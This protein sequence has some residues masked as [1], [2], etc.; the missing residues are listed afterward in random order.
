MVRISLVAFTFAASLPISA[1]VSDEAVESEIEDVAPEDVVSVTAKQLIAAYRVNEIR[2]N[3]LFQGKVISVSGIV[4]NVGEDIM[5][6]AYV[7][8]TDGSEFSFTRVQCFFGDSH[9]NEL[10][11]LSR[12][13]R[14]TLRGKGDGYLMNA[15]VRGCRVEQ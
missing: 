3:Q 5:G 2:A 15:F 6:D 10:A 1:C 8:L 9:R 13:D 4:D 14:V 7:S 12:G 11:R